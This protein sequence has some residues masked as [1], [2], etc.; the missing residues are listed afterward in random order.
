VEVKA[1][2]GPLQFLLAVLVGDSRLVVRR[3][4]S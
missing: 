4:V 3:R 2:F 1:E